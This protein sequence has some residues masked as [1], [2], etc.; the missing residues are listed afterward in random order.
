MNFN[1]V[2]TAGAATIDC[3]PRL[4]QN[5]TKNPSGISWRM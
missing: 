4:M 5:A 2:M 1:M 3:M